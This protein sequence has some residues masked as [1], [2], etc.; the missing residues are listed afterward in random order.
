MTSSLRPRNSSASAV[1][2][3]SNTGRI[4]I[5]EYFAPIALACA[6]AS[7]QLM[8]AVYCEGIITACTLSAPSASTATASVSA[9]SMPP[10]SP[11]SAPG[12]PFLPR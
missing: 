6:S 2:K 4:A 11:S 9:E 7:S 5:T 10:D 8:P 1:L 3:A 12:K